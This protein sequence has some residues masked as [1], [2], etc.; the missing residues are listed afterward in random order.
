MFMCT[1]YVP[2]RCKSNLWIRAPAT[3]LIYEYMSRIQNN[4]DKSQKSKFSEN[5]NHRN[6]YILNI[7]LE[8]TFWLFQIIK[9]IF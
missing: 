3:W 2:M 4:D 7:F 8:K 6:S 5:G 9:H 1:K